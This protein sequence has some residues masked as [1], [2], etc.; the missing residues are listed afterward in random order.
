[1]HYDY[2]IVGGG[3]HG[4]LAGLSLVKQ[5]PDLRVA[6]IEAAP[7]LG[8]NHIWSL[9]G[10][11]LTAGEMPSWARPLV[12]CRWPSHE[13]RF[14]SYKRTLPGCYLTLTSEN[15]HAET[16]CAFQASANCDL[17]LG[18]R[19]KPTTHGAIF[20]D[21]EELRA[22]LVLDARGDS[23]QAAP[24]NSG[25]QKFLGLELHSSVQ[26]S[27]TK[28]ML[29]DACVSQKDGYHFMYVLPF[30]KHRVFI[31]DTYFSD[32]A[33]MDHGEMRSN[34]L[35]YAAKLGISVSKVGRQE[36]G[37]LPMPWKEPPTPPT[38]AIGVRG[39]FSHPGTAYSLP[40]ALQVAELLASS[41]GP[42][43]AFR[44]LANLRTKI[45]RKS[46]FAY[47]LNLM[48][49][50]CYSPSQRANI[51]E[52]FYRLPNS[53]IERFYSLNLR[54]VDQARILSGRPPKGFS[55]RRAVHRGEARV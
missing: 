19:A 34:I 48:L 36:H 46:R 4:A 53:S 43:H 50:R 23:Q 11:D 33:S 54:A 20:D 26:H 38:N 40:F 31:E 47:L 13:V 37:V 44:R 5:R 39:G 7:R 30:S 12:A 1:M 8:G 6:L 18:R 55:I 29:M 27:L 3:L 42:E 2:L 45:A 51:F 16:L 52:K 10:S 22:E 25:F 41:P 49:F 17:F 28:P 15:L 32:S 24:S 9:H 35:A 14:Q 21:G